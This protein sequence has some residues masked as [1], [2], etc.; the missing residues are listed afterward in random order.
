M[1][2]TYSVKV[3][4]TF[5]IKHIPIMTELENAGMATSVKCI[6]ILTGL[7]LKKVVNFKITDIIDIYREICLSAAKVKILKKLPNEIEILGQKYVLVNPIKQ[8]I[9]WVIDSSELVKDNNPEMLAAFMYIEKGTVY[10]ETDANENIINSVFPRAAI[11]KEEMSINLYLGLVYK[12]AEVVKEINTIVG[13]DKKKTE[14]ES[15]GNQFAWENLILQVGKEF[16][17]DFH[18]VMKLNIKTFMH[19]TKVLFHNMTEKLKK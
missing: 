6:S 12:Y 3:P 15:S 18:D 10:G 8:P 11:F 16:N 1:V 19:Y 13:N 14:G 17:M 7:P 5:K 2:N 4:T 9:S